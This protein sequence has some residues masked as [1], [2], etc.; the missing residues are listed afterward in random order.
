IQQES[1]KPLRGRESDTFFGPFADTAPDHFEERKITWPFDVYIPRMPYAIRI[2][3]AVIQ[4]KPVCQKRKYPFLR[5]SPI[6]TFLEK[7]HLQL[8]VIQ[9][10]CPTRTAVVSLHVKTHSLDI[11]TFN[12]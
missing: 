11:H 5:H 7:N 9:L 4:Q 6:V 2:R 10:Q 1:N 8:F 12:F 3:I